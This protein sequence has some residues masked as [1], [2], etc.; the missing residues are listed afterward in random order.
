[1]CD[2]EA[3]TSNDGCQNG[4]SGG[5]LEAQVEA[6]HGNLWNGMLELPWT[7]SGHSWCEPLPPR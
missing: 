1:V 2:Y 6:V 4:K 7:P 5:N 3:D